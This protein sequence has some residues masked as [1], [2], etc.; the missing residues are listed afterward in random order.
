MNDLMVIE[1]RDPL[2]NPDAEWGAA[3]ARGMA[4]TGA[5]ACLMLVENG[6]FAGRAGAAVPWMARLIEA[7]VVVAADRYAL[8]ERGIDEG[9]L[10]GGVIA[11]E[12]GLVIDWLDAGAKVIWR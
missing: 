7:G 6:V 12:L 8:R 5:R 3:L 10:V 1:T 9:D 4:G 11:A 2:E